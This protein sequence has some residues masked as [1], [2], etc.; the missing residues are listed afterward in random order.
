MRRNKTQKEDASAFKVEEYVE[1]IKAGNTSNINNK[2]TG[3][4][5]YK[6]VKENESRIKC[7]LKKHNEDV[8]MKK[9]GSIVDRKTNLLD[10]KSEKIDA[11]NLS[12]Y[13]TQKE[14]DRI[15]LLALASSQFVTSLG[16][17]L[18]QQSLSIKKALDNREESPDDEADEDDGGDGENEQG[19][20]NEDEW[21]EVDENNSNNDDAKN[22]NN[23]QNK[24]H[25]KKKGN[26]LIGSRDLKRSDEFLEDEEEGE[27]MAEDEGSKGDEEMGEENN[28]E[29]YFDN[30]NEAMDEENEEGQEKDNEVNIEVISQGEMREDTDQSSDEERTDLE[31]NATG[32]IFEQLFGMVR[33]NNNEDEEEDDEEEQEVESYNQLQLFESE[34]E[35]HFELDAFK[36]IFK[37]LNKIKQSLE[38]ENLLKQILDKHRSE[39]SSSG[40]YTDYWNEQIFFLLTNIQS[41]WFLRST[42]YDYHMNIG[43]LSCQ[44]ITLLLLDPIRETTILPLLALNLVG[45]NNVYSKNTENNFI[46]KTK[47]IELL[48]QYSMRAPSIFFKQFNL[49]TLEKYLLKDTAKH[50][51][52]QSF[53][54]LDLLILF[55]IQ[56]VPVNKDGQIN[57]L[58]LLLWRMID[59]LFEIRLSKQ[60]EKAPELLQKLQEDNACPLHQDVVTAM[61]DFI[62]KNSTIEIAK[63]GKIYRWFQLLAQSSH[64]REQLLYM[65]EQLLKEQVVT[66]EK[67]INTFIERAKASLNNINESGLDDYTNFFIEM[68]PQ[69]PKI[70]SIMSSLIEDDQEVNQQFYNLIQEE[71]FNTDLR[72]ISEQY[73]EVFGLITKLQDN[74]KFTLN[75]ITQI[76]LNSIME[77][78]FHYCLYLAKTKEQ[79]VEAQKAQTD[80]KKGKSRGITRMPTMKNPILLERTDSLTVGDNSEFQDTLIQWVRQ[81]NILI[82]SCLR[83]LKLEKSN[84]VLWI[85]KRFPWILNFEIKEKFLR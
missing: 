45:Y 31:D 57:R 71:T 11:D 6:V 4:S 16:Q 41:E 53:S 19:A 18:E 9:L 49:S 39:I 37:H 80:S 34:P 72:K 20:D 33:R 3:A 8:V 62:E 13:N 38:D 22:S 83:S 75:N 17:D 70:L 79:S 25:T 14:F 77:V 32:G 73:M 58:T 74:K 46:L 35:K 43:S 42:D 21:E 26:L 67:V 82:N 59:F 23:N 84:K 47:I 2:E 63:A 10:S 81:H 55:Y 52:S 30:E 68:E 48:Y 28:G 24:R 66:E 15:L 50:R 78:P 69:V 51:L 61:A 36:A 29:E 40:A 27:E 12:F 1:Q 64:Y 65:C 7:L 76:K 56:P 5:F 44:M 85:V 54:I 60:V